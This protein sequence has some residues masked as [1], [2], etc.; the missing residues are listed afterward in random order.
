MKVLITGGSG[1]IG[2]QIIKK[3]S[4]KKCELHITVNENITSDINV[5]EHKVDLLNFKEVEDL[6]KLVKPTHLLHLAWYAEPPY[7]WDSNKNYEWLE[8]SIK[9]IKL[10]QE[11]NGLRLVISGSCAEYL[12]KSSLL[13]ESDECSDSISLYSECKNNLR[14]TVFSEIGSSELKIAWGRIFFPYGKSENPKRFISSIFKNLM[15]DEES[16]CHHPNLIRDYIHVNDVANAFILLLENEYHGL[17]NIGSGVGISLGE[18]GIKIANQLNKKNLLILGD[19]KHH[20]IPQII[21]NNSLLKS[22][23]RSEVYN[24]DKGI[25][26][27]LDTSF[28]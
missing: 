7:F 4:K 26:S 17:V 14:N 27:Y 15:N 8:S 25:S 11:N 22:L 13:K 12:M 16:I 1:F 24:L 9:L 23:G 2:T 19:K 5:I 18:I 3:L 20:E 10:F 6:I 28:I 21:S